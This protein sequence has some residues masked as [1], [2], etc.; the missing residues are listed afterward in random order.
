MVTK[1][2]FYDQV[3]N[4]YLSLYDFAHLRSHPLSKFLIN[5]ETIAFKER[6]WQLH[7]IL[8]EALE[9][10]NMGHAVPPFSK[11]W[12]RY[13]LMLLRYVEV[14]QPQAVAEQLSISRRQYYREHAAAIE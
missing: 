8:L 10:L 12:R 14:L 2:E 4:A 3:S 5:D 6:G 11:E 13:Q 7:N 9:E 1:T